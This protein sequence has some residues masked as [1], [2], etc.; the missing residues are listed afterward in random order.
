LIA[1]WQQYPAHILSFICGIKV[2]FASLPLLTL[3]FASYSDSLGY[4]RELQIS[5]Y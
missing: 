2:T 3:F 1:E 4:G 5:I